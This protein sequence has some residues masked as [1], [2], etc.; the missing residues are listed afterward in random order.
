MHPLVA[1]LLPE[2]V[3]AARRSFALLVDDVP[4]SEVV[5][6]ALYSDPDGATIV[7]AAGTRASYDALVTRHPE[8]SDYF[9]WSPQEWGRSSMTITERGLADPL[10]PAHERL[11]DLHDLV[12]AERPPLTLRQLRESVWQLC[13]AVLAELHRERWFDDYPNA[14]RAVEVSD[15]ELDHG[16]WT[17]WV[18]QCN[19]P[20]VAAEFRAHLARS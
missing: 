15:H 9:R 5:G 19:E 17:T 18:Q 3:G 10:D 4:P 6:F 13:A 11:D 8:A 12:D 2:V 14:V 16:L 1:G 7:A 20:D